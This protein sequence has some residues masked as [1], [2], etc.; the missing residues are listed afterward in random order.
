MRTLTVLNIHK[1]LFSQKVRNYSKFQILDK[2]KNLDNRF[3]VPDL[4]LEIF[5]CPF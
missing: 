1:I 3:L 2:L 5:F 4:D